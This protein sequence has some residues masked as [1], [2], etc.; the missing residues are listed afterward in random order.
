MEVKKNKKSKSNKKVFSKNK[1]ILKKLLK[2][3]DN[4]KKD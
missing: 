1:K 2:N 3:M 4:F